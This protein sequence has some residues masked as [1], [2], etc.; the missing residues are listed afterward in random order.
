MLNK[1]QIKNIEENKIVVFATL[2]GKNNDQPRAVIVQPSRIEKD[3]II[4][5]SIQMEKTIENV[6]K[7]KKCFIDVYMPEKDDLQYKLEGEA[8]V[9][10]SGKL[11]EEIKHFE[12]S[13]NLPSESPDGLKVHE[14]IVFHI[15]SFEQT[16]G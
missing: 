8:E 12:E 13:E 14:I 15:K 7:N 6:K 10:S 9:F 16:N 3:R 4:L 1:Q 2:G 11:F 5:S